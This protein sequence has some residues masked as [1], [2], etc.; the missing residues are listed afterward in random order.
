MFYEMCSV[1][2][3]GNK[4]QCTQ[5]L[6]AVKPL[7]NGAAFEVVDGREVWHPVWDAQ[8]DHSINSQFLKSVIE[9]IWNNEKVSQSVPMETCTHL[10]S[11]R[12]FTTP[13]GRGN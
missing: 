5:E 9:C 6:C 13:K 12:I 10:S 7:E 2:M 1:E 11:C 4:T 3:S 8:V